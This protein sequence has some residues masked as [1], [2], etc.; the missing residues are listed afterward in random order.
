MNDER[1]L[2]AIDLCQ[3]PLRL[4]TM[5]KLIARFVYQKHQLAP[6]TTMGILTLG[7]MTTWHT[8]FTSN[9][10]L[11]NESLATLRPALLSTT[12][13]FGTLLECVRDVDGPELRVIL[14][15][16]RD[17]APSFD[18]ASVAV[19][20]G[21]GWFLDILYIHDKISAQNNVQVVFDSLW[22]LE[23]ADTRFYEVSRNYKRLL[24][25]MT[26]LLGR[27]GQ[28]SNSIDS[29]TWLFTDASSPTPTAVV[30]SPDRL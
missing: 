15:Y 25:A 30:P 23:S 20:F 24:L 10:E 3:E 16:H 14:I 21:R 2:F 19:F 12:W 29:H 9:G 27:P 26:G 6:S 8:P 18:Q 1:I 4:E 11:I 28:R 17:F 22:E 7:D 13:D 5:V